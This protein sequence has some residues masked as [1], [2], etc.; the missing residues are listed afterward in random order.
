M[1]NKKITEEEINA[2]CENL[3][4]TKSSNRRSAAK[5]IRKY[6]LTRLGDELYNAY[7]KENLGDS[8]GND[9]NTWKNWL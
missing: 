9:S 7:L 4:S 2:I 3:V 1:A 8:N 6:N 5:K